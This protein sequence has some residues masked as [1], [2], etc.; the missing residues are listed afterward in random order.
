M[1]NICE[2]GTRCGK[3]NPGDI[4]DITTVSTMGKNFSNLVEAI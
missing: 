1:D 4:E 3:L 2:V